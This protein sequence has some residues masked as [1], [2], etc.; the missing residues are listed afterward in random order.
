MLRSKLLFRFSLSP[1]SQDVL[2]VDNL[3]HKVK[4]HI[5]VVVRGLVPDTRVLTAE[6]EEP[7]GGSDFIFCSAA[8]HRNRL[9]A[10]RRTQRA[11]FSS[12]RAVVNLTW[13]ATLWK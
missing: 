2:A 5:I 8:D 13:L 12:F 3:L 1:L 10:F 6:G 9:C 11:G 4:R 7:A